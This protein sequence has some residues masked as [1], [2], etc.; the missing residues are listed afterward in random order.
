MIC[1]C[2]KKGAARVLLVMTVFLAAAVLTCFFTAVLRQ[3]CGFS[4]HTVPEKGV[5]SQILRVAVISPWAF[6]GFESISHASEEFSFKIRIDS[7]N[8][9]SQ[10]QIFR[11]VA[12]SQPAILLSIVQQVPA[13]DPYSYNVCFP[14]C[15]RLRSAV[16]HRRASGHCCRQ[17]KLLSP[18]SAA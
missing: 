9:L 10:N 18:S 3:D 13:G 17:E 8:I 7:V 2:C 5:I 1:S 4:P 6:I 11:S 12:G 15:C 16:W 14:N